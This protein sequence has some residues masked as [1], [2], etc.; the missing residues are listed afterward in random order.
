MSKSRR[1]L[2]VEDEEPV[3]QALQLKLKRYGIESVIVSDGQEALLE[4]SKNKFD[5]I[6]LD[7][8]LP[9]MDGFDVLE[10]IRKKGNQVPVLVISN[11][12]QEE[13]VQRAK[14]LGALDYF[15]KSNIQLS[16][17]VEKIRSAIKND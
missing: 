1:V 14:S 13:D 7:L 4:L 16:Q 17:I 15:V 10:E 5:L 2:I 11:L 3:A 8:I 6:T 12:G 9:K